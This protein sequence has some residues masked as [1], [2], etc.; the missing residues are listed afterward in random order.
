MDVS[1]MMLLV[2]ARAYLEIIVR[3]GPIDAR[4]TQLRHESYVIYCRSGGLTGQKQLTVKGRTSK[5]TFSRDM[6]LND[7]APNVSRR[8]QMQTSHEAGLVFRPR[9]K[10]ATNL[11]KG[12]YKLLEDAVID[13]ADKGQGAVV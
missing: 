13:R 3:V 9:G 6:P 5:R 7:R 4:S 10:Q 12:F 1:G 11:K 8:W 2:T